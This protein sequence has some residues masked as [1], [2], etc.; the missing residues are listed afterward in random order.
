MLGASSLEARATL[1]SLCLDELQ[2]AIERVDFGRDVEDA[3]VRLVVTGD[4]SRQA[5]IVGATS[6][7]HGLVVGRR[8]AADGVDEPHWKWFGG[9]VANVRGGGV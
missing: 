8:F 5:P 6:Q 2:L 1:T 7:I 4:L 3:S 9:G